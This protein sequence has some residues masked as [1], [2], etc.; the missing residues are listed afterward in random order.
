MD[1]TSLLIFLAIGAVARWL[2]VVILKGGGFGLVFRNRYLLLIGLLLFYIVS[3]ARQVEVQRLSPFTPQ[4]IPA[5]LAATGLV[6][7]S[8]GGLLKVAAVAE[9]IESDT[10]EFGR[11][12]FGHRCPCRSARADPVDEHDRGAGSTDGVSNAHRGRLIAA[13]EGLQTST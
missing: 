12:L 13:A 5:V 1:L 10:G 4:G 9:E 11:Q 2:A 3:G 6:F 8:Y 7:V